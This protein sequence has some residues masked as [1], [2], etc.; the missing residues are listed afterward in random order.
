MKTDDQRAEIKR[1]LTNLLE[2]PP[3]E[4]EL[5]R[6]ADETGKPKQW[7]LGTLLQKYYVPGSGPDV[8]GTEAKL[9]EDAQAREEKTV[10]R[11]LSKELERKN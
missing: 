2:L 9:Y 1:A 8:L 4:L 3:R 5:K 10:I 7:P 11:K 6:Y